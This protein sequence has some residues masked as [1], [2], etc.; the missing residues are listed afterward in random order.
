[1]IWGRNDFLLPFLSDTLST[2]SFKDESLNAHVYL[3]NTRKPQ[4]C[5]TRKVQKIHLRWKKVELFLNRMVNI[6]E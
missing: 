6:F 4:T 5:Y 2:Y 3:L 1:M